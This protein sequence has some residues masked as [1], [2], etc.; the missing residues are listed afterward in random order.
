MSSPPSTF[1]LPHIRPDLVGLFRARLVSHTNYSS[2]MPHAYMYTKS[3]ISLQFGAQ[4][5]E[6]GHRTERY[7]STPPSN[8]TTPPPVSDPYPQDTA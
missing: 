2:P 1:M 4:R 6:R 7:R 5:D 8:L 3:K